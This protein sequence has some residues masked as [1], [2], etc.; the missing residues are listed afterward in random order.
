VSQVTVRGWDPATKQ[1][2]V[3]TATADDLPGSGSGTSGPQEAQKSL[4]NR[5]DVV[6]DAVVTSEEEAREL[7][8]SLLR[9]RAYEFI[10]GNGEIVGLPDLRP[11]DNMDLDGLGRRFSGSYY[12]KKVEHTIGSSGFRTRFEVRRV[13]DGGT[14]SRGATA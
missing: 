10:T 6:V 8:I 7:A 14:Q 2:I 12:V 4:G 11:G 5:Q 9:E 1:A 3:V 13:F